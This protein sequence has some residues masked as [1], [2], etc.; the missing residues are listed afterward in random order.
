MQQIGQTRSLLLPELTPA[1]PGSQN[2]TTRKVLLR[3][4]V[5]AIPELAAAST[6]LPHLTQVSEV[7]NKAADHFDPFVSD[8]LAFG[9]AKVSRGVGAISGY[10]DLL[11]V[12]S[13]PCRENVRLIRLRHDRYQWE[14]L[15]SRNL[16]V[17]TL[18]TNEVGWWF[19]PVDCPVQQICVSE[20]GRLVAVRN[21]RG[22]SFLRPILQ[23]KLV[24]Y[25]VPSD[26]IDG[27][28]R[29]RIPSRLDPS[30]RVDMNNPLDGGE[31]YI[32][33]DINPWNE[34]Q[35]AVLD[36]DGLWTVYQFEGMYWQRY[37][38]VG[39]TKI[40]KAFQNNALNAK[41]IDNWGALLWAGDSTTLIICSRQAITM[42]VMGLEME[43]LSLPNFNLGSGTDVILDIKRDPSNFE[44]VFLLTSSQ[45]FWLR[46]LAGHQ[47]GDLGRNG[48]ALEILLS[49]RH[50]R[51][52][53]D[54]SLR[55]R[56][57]V[58][59]NTHRDTPSTTLAYESTNLV[60]VYSRRSALITCF[61]V[62]MNLQPKIAVSIMDPYDLSPSDR[63]DGWKNPG[64]LEFATLILS[65]LESRA[66]PSTEK[67]IAFPSVQSEPP[68]LF[69]MIAIE[70]DLSVNAVV[71]I[72][73]CRV[74]DS[75]LRVPLILK[76]R[77]RVLTSAE[78]IEEDDFIAP[79][80][81]V[82]EAANEAEIPISSSV[83]T[84]AL[85]A[86][87]KNQ[88]SYI[89]T[90][91]KWLIDEIK[92]RSAAEWQQEIPLSDF[93]ELVDSIISEASF[94]ENGI[95]TL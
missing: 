76:S 57:A 13:G 36:A 86:H 88:D 56:L 94:P 90:N 33:V 10:V 1:D 21:G 30:W 65:P 22:I 63:Q 18:E 62:G 5:K 72:K 64:V 48:T 67:Q 34:R 55:L 82:F 45:I 20:S 79:N 93:K 43:T 66:V 53:V 44:R 41:T 14:G 58:L 84:D 54:L 47:R 19:G 83:E 50:H 31:P 16:F 85:K 37:D 38:I 49:L 8:L 2:V 12:A 23:K 32:D 26:Y 78:T 27:D 77:Q 24:S 35:V 6:L 92:R 42:H 4:T 28:T 25:T 89:I 60:L 11:V 95:Q 15:R 91:A 59:R 39:H 70:N 71:L 17:P 7:V 74:K 73:E 40:S 80:G 87:N 81:P 69:H 51:S 29:A 46:V 52:P 75:V 61:T 9:K 68:N 3:S